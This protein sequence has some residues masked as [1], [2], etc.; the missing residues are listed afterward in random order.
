MTDDE[1]RAERQK[2][3]DWI[4]GPENDGRLTAGSSAYLDYC[5]DVVEEIDAELERRSE[6][7]H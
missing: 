5:L 7:Q 2:F 1:L 3:Q 4:D 6:D